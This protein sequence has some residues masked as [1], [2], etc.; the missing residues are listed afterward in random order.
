MKTVPVL[1]TALLATVAA[2]GCFFSTEGSGTTTGTNA[3]EPAS[4]ATLVVKWT[5]TGGSD[6]NEC[7]K[8]QAKNIEVSI[9]DTSGNEVGAYQQTCSAFSTSITLRPGTYTAT[10]ALLDDQGRAR[11]T[12]APISQFTLRPNESLTVPVDFPSNSFR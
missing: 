5:I 3:T 7:I 2:S 10:A 9:V 6:P 1:F 11:T 8:A 4:T 12:D